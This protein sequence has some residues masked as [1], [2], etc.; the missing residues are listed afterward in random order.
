MKTTNYK[1]LLIF[2]FFSVSFNCLS[3]INLQLNGIVFQSGT[4]NAISSVS[5]PTFTVPVGKV[6]KLERYKR[7]R[8]WVNGVYIQDTYYNVNNGITIDDAPLWLNEGDTFYFNYT[9]NC[10]GAS[11]QLDWFFS[12]LEFNK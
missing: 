8:L 6:W 1:K 2:I 11:Y 9:N 12:A 7:E 4:N 5:S 3:Q 10:C